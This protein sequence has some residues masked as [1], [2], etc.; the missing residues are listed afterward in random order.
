MPY[1]TFSV[2]A[3]V[4]VVADTEEQAREAICAAAEYQDEDVDYNGMSV[5]V[6]TYEC[7]SAELADIDNQE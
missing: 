1:Y 7:E 6:P 5:Y 2:T 3:A 4:S